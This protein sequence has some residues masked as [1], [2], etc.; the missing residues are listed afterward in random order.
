MPTTLKVSHCS[1]PVAG[2]V[3]FSITGGYYVTAQPIYVW[4]GQ[5]P[6]Q[7]IA[8]AGI[9]SVLSVRDP[10]EVCRSRPSI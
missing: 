3:C 2:N 9:L 1:L 8:R 10:Q 5:S 7:V 6:Y 4:P